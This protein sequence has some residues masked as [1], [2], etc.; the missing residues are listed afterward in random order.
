MPGPLNLFLFTIETVCE[1]PLA[2]A[3]A[4]SLWEIKYKSFINELLLGLTYLPMYETQI[5]H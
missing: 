2:Y 3:Q 5:M 4:N 1:V